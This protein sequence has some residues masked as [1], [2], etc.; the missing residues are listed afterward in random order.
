MAHRINRRDFVK[1]TIGSL[2][3]IP[4]VQVF[5]DGEMPMLKV[6]DA[7]AKALGY[8]EDSSTVDNATHPKHTPEQLCVNCALYTGDA[9][10]EAGGCGIFPG[11]LV[12]AKGWCVAYA[13][14]P[15]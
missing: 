14:K 6:D 7:Q 4:I 11:K 9:D 10:S 12:A 1:A 3:A 2:A 5:A 8:V 15:A 13:A